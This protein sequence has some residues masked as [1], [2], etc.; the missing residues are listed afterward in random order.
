MAYRTLLA[1][2]GCW[3]AL[4]VAARAEDCVVIVGNGTADPLIGVSM[5]AEFA[6]PGSD[7]DHNVD[8]AIGGKLY[9]NQS[10]RVQWDCPSRNISYVATGLFS[11]GIKRTSTPFTPRPDASGRPETA[12]IE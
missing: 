12:W 3:L 6:R 1:A 11:N 2:A 8:V 10:V 9:Q 5:R 4:A 7:A